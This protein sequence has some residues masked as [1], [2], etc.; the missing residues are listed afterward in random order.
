MGGRMTKPRIHRTPEQKAALLRE[1]HLAK[2]PVSDVC[3]AAEVQPSVF[4]YW[5]KLLFD[6]APLALEGEKRSNREKELQ[7]EIAA[8]KAKLAEKEAIIARKDSV[9][10]EISGEYVA[11]KKA[12]GEP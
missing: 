6:N 3:E 1:H 4:Y 7:V 11:L 12:R 9:I 5:Q 8:L 2:K 10:A